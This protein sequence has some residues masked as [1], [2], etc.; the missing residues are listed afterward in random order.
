MRGKS[1]TY[2]TVVIEG[3]NLQIGQLQMVEISGAT[4]KTLFG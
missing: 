3:E 1:D 4:T 2:K